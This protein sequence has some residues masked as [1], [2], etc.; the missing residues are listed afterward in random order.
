MIQSD[1]PR[2]AFLVDTCILLHFMRGTGLAQR[3]SN[4]YQ[5]G[6]PTTPTAIC[7]VTVGE[8]YSLASRLGWGEKRKESLKGLLKFLRVIPICSPQIHQY[9]AL[10]DCHTQKQG[11]K[12]GKN[13]I[14][15]AATAKA[16]DW[17][18]LTTDKDFSCVR[19]Q[20]LVS[21]LIVDSDTATPI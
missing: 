14:W 4:L 13:D 15:I 20:N 9:Y 10:I 7:E 3:L 1:S 8:I 2:G 11:Q 21:C 12:M 5:L 16:I 18:L 6:D 19:D 17:Q